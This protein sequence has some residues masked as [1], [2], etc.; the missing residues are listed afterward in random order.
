MPA[1]ETRQKILFQHCD[2]A[3]I[4]FYPRYVE[5]FNAVTEAWFERGLEL[6]FA[7][8][9]MDR[10]KGVPTAH[11]E[12][13]FKAPSRLGEELDFSLTVTKLGRS[14]VTLSIEAKCD[15]EERLGGTVTLVHIDGGRMKSEA[16]PED[17]RSKIEKF[18]V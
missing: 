12:V 13:S 15:G 8:L 17:L 4:V 6:S 9:V 14:S 2:P 5:M 11:L 7:E 16:W 18:V 10:K 1:F 3:G